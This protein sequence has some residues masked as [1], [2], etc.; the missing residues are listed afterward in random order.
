MDL[1]DLLR[2]LWRN[3]TLS[4][5]LVL[6]L[7]ASLYGIVSTVP[8]QYTAEASVLVLRQGDAVGS[9]PYAMVDPSQT[10][11]ATMLVKQLSSPQ[12]RNELTKTG[13]RADYAIS[14]ESG[15]VQEKTPFLTV[16]VTADSP[17]AA[18]QTAALVL[19]KARSQLW[20]AQ[21]AARVPLAQQ[22]FLTDVVQPNQVSPSLKAQTRALALT[23][24]IG[25]IFALIMVALTDRVRYRRRLR[26]EAKTSA[27]PTQAPRRDDRS[28]G[29]PA[30]A[31]N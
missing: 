5:V 4:I 1:I 28:N 6:A 15:E 13:A 18:S 29:Y 9:N 17:A 12:S 10:Q 11:A 14:N 7:A 8:P 26:A 19:N 24:A 23:S 16:T 30:R 31:R 3:L 2:M 22:L 27:Q 21:S 25:L 20:S